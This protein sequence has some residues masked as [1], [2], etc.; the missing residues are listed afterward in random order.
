[1]RRA[2]LLILFLLAVVVG[3]GGMMVAQGARGPV[4]I[5]TVTALVVLLGVGALVWLRGNGTRGAGVRAELQELM[6]LLDRFQTIPNRDKVLKALDDA[7]RAID[8]DDYSTARQAITKAEEFVLEDADD[9]DGAG[10][11]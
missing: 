4:L 6:Q 7:K 9:A 3:T 1:M 8:A 2:Y 11:A 10:D 5:L